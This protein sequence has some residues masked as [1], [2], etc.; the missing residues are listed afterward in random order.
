MILI[1]S[2]RIDNANK[3]GHFCMAECFG[4]FVFGQIIRVTNSKR[5][6]IQSE[7][8]EQVL[9]KS[10]DILFFSASKFEYDKIDNTLTLRDYFP[11]FF[12]DAE[13]KCVEMGVSLKEVFCISKD[14]EPKRP[15]FSTYQLAKAEYRKLRQNGAEN[16]IIHN[17]IKIYYPK[18]IAK[19][20][21]P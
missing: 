18:N 16:L 4:Q 7:L 8:R 9:P 5:I 3:K 17:G 20:H 21:K 6:I 1:N 12:A 13:K 11:N 10:C 14:F 19:R 2:Y 15:T